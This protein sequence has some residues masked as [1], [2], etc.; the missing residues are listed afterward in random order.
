VNFT[1]PQPETFLFSIISV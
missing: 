1:E